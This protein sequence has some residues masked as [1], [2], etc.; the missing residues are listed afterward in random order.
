MTS[1]ALRLPGGPLADERNRWL[2]EGVVAGIGGYGNCV[3]VPTVA[4]EV[5]FDARYNGNIL[6]NA[7]SLGL[8]RAGDEV[9]IWAPGRERLELEQDG[10]MALVME[11]L[12]GHPLRTLLRRPL[13]VDLRNVYEPEKMH[14]A[15][16][17]YECVGRAARDLPRG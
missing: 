4:G 9:R 1:S 3:G 14:Q 15:G 17:E 7:F 11:M 5:M 10:I 2:F 8:A 16:F 13:V 12:H 6:V